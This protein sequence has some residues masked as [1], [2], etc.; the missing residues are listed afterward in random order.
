MVRKETCSALVVTSF[1]EY[2]GVLIT[3]PMVLV[4][5]DRIVRLVS[6]RPETVG[7]TVDNRLDKGLVWMILEEVG[8]ETDIDRGD[9]LKDFR[10][11]F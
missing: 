2:V 3:D 7:K 1:Q 5:D 9:N 8:K 6:Q 10:I 11:V 4:I